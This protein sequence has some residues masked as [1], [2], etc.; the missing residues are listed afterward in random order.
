MGHLFMRLPCVP[1]CPNPGHCI[2]IFS[3]KTKT[4][5]ENKTIPSLRKSKGYKWLVGGRIIPGSQD[6]QTKLTSSF[7]LSAFKYTTLKQ[8]GEKEAYDSDISS[9]HGFCVNSLWS[10][11]FVVM[12]APINEMDIGS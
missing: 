9:S 3:K 1:M 12:V 11:H 4:K 2:I 7:L 5:N 10:D 8:G 6:H